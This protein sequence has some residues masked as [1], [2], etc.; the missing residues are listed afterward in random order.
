MLSMWGLKSLCE[1]LSCTSADNGATGDET[2]NGASAGQT[3]SDTSRGGGT[4]GCSTRRNAAG[5][6]TT[7]WSGSATSRRSDARWGGWNG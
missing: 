1:G 4:T 2:S 7:V 3:T 6:I 5:A